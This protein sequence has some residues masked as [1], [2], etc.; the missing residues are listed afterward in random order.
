MMT[1]RDRLRK[2]ISHAP[3][4]MKRPLR[5]AMRHRGFHRPQ[6][7]AVQMP[8]LRTCCCT[9]RRM[10][11]RLRTAHHAG[12]AA[13]RHLPNRIGSCKSVQSRSLRRADPCVRQSRDV[14]PF[15]RSAATAA[16]ASCSGRRDAPPVLRSSFRRR[17][18]DARG[19]L[20]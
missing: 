8:A 10:H 15:D 2:S 6:S 11:C 3:R 19:W 18:D 9:T 1:S 13:A 20:A 4:S 12:H 7:Q 14:L 16:S 17:I 5:I